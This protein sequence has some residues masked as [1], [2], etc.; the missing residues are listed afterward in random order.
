MGN[1]YRVGILGA[2]GTVGQ[3]FIQLLENHPQFEITALAA[4]DRSQGKSYWHAA[5]WKLPTPMPE[6]VKAIRVQAIEPNLDCDLVFSSLPS[7]VAKE[8]EEAFARA[9]YPVVSN[10]SSF[11]MEDDIPLLIPEINADHLGLIETQR[12]QRGFRRGFIVTNPNCAVISFAPPLAAL[13]RRF[14]VESVIVTT[15]Q[16]ISGAGYPG[17][18]SLDIIDNTIPFISGEEPKVETEAQKIL[19]RFRNETIEP[20]DF[21]VS[22]QCNRVPV[23]D[24]HT[25]SVR[26]RLRN[27]ATLEDVREAMASFPSLDLY[28]SPKHFIFVCDEPD[29]PQPRFDR[30]NGKGMTITVGRLFPDN[31]FDYRFVALSHNTI[32]GAAGAAILNAELLISKNLISVR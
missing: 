14:G 27:T 17:V 32:R 7:S 3:R 26:V 6:K 25:A 28:S 13:D 22:A 10:S 12:Q 8:T 18:P 1:R 30:D 19:G 11:R 23:I 21:V 15:M 5:N 29:R 31:I 4:S 9:G 16:A 2:T 20:A 24:G